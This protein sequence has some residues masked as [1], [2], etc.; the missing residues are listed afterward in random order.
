MT[1]ICPAD[2]APEVRALD[3]NAA[4]A[5]RPVMTDAIPPVGTTPYW[6][7]MPPPRSRFEAMVPLAVRVA[8][9]AWNVLGALFASALPVSDDGC[10]VLRPLWAEEAMHRAFGFLRLVHALDR[11]DERSCDNPVA[12][13]PAVAVVRDLVARFRE[14][15]SCGEREVLPCSAIL[16]DVVTGLGALFGGPANITVKTKIEDVSLPGY[17]RRALVLAAVELLS[18]ALLHGFVGRDA[19][20]ID[21]DLIAIG[22]HDACLCVADNGIGFTDSPPNLECGVAA[23]LAGLL[24][25]DVAYD[26]LAGRTI[27]EIVFPVAALWP[28]H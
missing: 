28:G 14:L 20:R 4:W 24:E 7:P 15:E 25:A 2:A 19:G 16:R 18:N 12:A 8:P 1:L 6:N 17:K 13:G 26:R 27:A 3:L 22:P 9:K 21:V 23:G 10:E 5:L 11:R